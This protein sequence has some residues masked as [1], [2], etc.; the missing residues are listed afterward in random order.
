MC[1]CPQCGRLMRAIGKG[2]LAC[3]GCLLLLMVEPHE[4]PEPVGPIA[5]SVYVTSLTS[6]APVISSFPIRF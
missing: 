2:L 6:S 3:A 1:I 5:P 4:P